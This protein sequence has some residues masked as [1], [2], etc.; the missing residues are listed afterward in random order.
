[1]DFAMTGMALTSI[2]PQS[3]PTSQGIRDFISDLRERQ[4]QGGILRRASPALQ[5][6]IAALNIGEI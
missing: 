3:G 4:S 2:T 5:A 1:M 6:E